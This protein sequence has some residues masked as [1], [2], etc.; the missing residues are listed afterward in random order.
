MLCSICSGI[1]L[2]SL[3][4]ISAAESLESKA[5]QEAG[6]SQHIEGQFKHHDDIFGIRGSANN[7]CELC[8]IIIKAFNGRKIEDE[9]IARGMP[10]VLSS[11]KNNKLTASIESP[12]GLI[13]LCGF[14][15]YI[16]PGK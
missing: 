15:V 2:S 1:D 13:E 5:C 12:E 14:D 6:H 10:I 16:D 9:N 4:S 11:N 3:L 8:A 7:G